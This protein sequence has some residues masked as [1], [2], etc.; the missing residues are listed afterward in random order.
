[1]RQK[2][3]TEDSATTGKHPSQVEYKIHS[4]QMTEAHQ[5]VD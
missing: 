5:E 2:E 4:D 1:M 3:Q